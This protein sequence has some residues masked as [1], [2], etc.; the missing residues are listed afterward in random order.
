MWFNYVT[1]IA[2]KAFGIDHSSDGH[3]CFLLL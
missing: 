1:N 3:Q 2:I